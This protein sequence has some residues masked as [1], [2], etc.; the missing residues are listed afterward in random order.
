MPP[1]PRTITSN[2]R[3]AQGLSD[4]RV[5]A[6]PVEY[7]TVGN[8]ILPPRRSKNMPH[9]AQVAFAVFTNITDEH[10][11]QRVRRRTFAVAPRSP[12]SPS[13]LPIVPKPRSN[14][15]ASPLPD[16]QR[17]FGRKYRVNVGTQSDITPPVAGMHSGT[18]SPRRR[19]DVIQPNSRSQRS[20]SPFSRAA[21]PKT[22][23]PGIRAISICQCASCGSS[24]RTS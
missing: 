13:R 15:A 3:P 22:E 19:C 21:S 4:N 12:A 24:M 16:I 14:R 7:Y 6:R 9:A 2:R 23:A 11:R 18:R 5:R 17:V 20:A 8:R 1:G 10:Q